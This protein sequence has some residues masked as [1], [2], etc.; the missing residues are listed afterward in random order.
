[1]RKRERKKKEAKIDVAETT[2]PITKQREKHAE[3]ATHNPRK[4]K[5]MKESFRKVWKYN[6]LH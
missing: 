3:A 1:M 2:P 4:A 5:L 6:T